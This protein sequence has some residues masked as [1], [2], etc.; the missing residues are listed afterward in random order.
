MTLVSL[1][2]G[3]GCNAG[4]ATRGGFGDL[5]HGGGAGLG[6]GGLQDGGGTELHVI[7]N[8]LKGGA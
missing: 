2:L 3:E 6:R 8:E 4:P 1:I 7:R 5:V